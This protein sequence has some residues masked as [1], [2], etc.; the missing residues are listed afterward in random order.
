MRLLR[1]AFVL[2]FV[3]LVFW[4]SAS[5]TAAKNPA[6]KIK[7]ADIHRLGPD[8]QVVFAG[9]QYLLSGHQTRQFLKLPNDDR[10]HEWL[11]KFWKQRDPTPTTPKNEMLVEH[12]IRVNLAQQ[13]YKSKKWPGWDKR[14]EVFI[15]Y[16]P[17]DYRGKIW[18]EVTVNRGVTP[19]GELWYFRKHDM[20]VSFQ[21]FGLRGEFIYSIDPLG[22]AEGLSPEMVEFLLYDTS[23][24]LTKRIPQNLLVHFAGP[25]QR[26]PPQFVDIVREQAYYQNKPR[27]LLEDIDAL[28]NPDMPEMMPRDMS[29]LFQ[30]ETVRK[31]A[32]N[33]EITLE[34]HPSSYPFNFD[35]KELPF[36]FAV[37]QFKGGEDVNR[38]EVQLELPLTI[39]AEAGAAFEETY[40][41]EVVIWDSEFNEVSRRERD[42][43][44]RKGPQIESWS[45]L[46]PTQMVMSLKEGYYR[47]GIS[48][49]GV[50][51]GRSS[52]YR[53]SFSCE[54][55]GV[56]LGLSDIVFARHIAQAG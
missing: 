44:L 8:M 56:V 14:G 35:R 36:Y 18:G 54:P 17:P 47:M 20:L 32:N 53:T 12:R 2:T 49:E 25:I 43:V 30:K 4:D 51:H 37:D 11:D 55:F 22:A 33:F 29:I 19:P 42:I 34:E 10:R 48:V 7:P 52:S 24:S 16:G 45:N 3:L 28:I 26:D 5:D 50:H 46:I 41:A 40:H 15:R 23:E 27:E 13:F 31:V 21:N 39:E 9:I 1:I 38:V 6:Y